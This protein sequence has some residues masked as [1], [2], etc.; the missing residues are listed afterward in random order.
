MAAG[1]CIQ[2]LVLVVGIEIA[3]AS[4]GFSELAALQPVLPVGA[5]ARKIMV[6]EKSGMLRVCLEQTVLL[7]LHGGTVAIHIGFFDVEEMRID[8]VAGAV[9]ADEA[10]D[11]AVGAE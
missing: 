1:P 6:H 5:G 4:L 7:P 11:M 3:P 2:Y 8:T 10:F 9:W